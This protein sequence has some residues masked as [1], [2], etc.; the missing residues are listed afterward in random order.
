MP[1]AHLVEVLTVGE[2][3]IAEQYRFESGRLRSAASR[4]LLRWLLGSYLNVRPEHA[5]LQFGA[6]GKPELA[7]DQASSGLR[8]NVAHCE[9]VALYALTRRREVG[10]DLERPRPMPDAADIAE[11]F[12]AA[13]EHA[14]L[15]VRA[16]G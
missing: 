9:D 3:E 12:F 5:R 15:L 8:F 1:H 11:R 2:R 13:D 4:G 6:L 10:V 14:A 16:A 7:G